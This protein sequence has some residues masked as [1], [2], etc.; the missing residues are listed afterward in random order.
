MDFVRR[1]L[2]GLRPTS[3]PP[4]T[5]DAGHA[6][7]QLLVEA[8]VALAEDRLE[9]DVERVMHVVVRAAHALT[10]GAAV[11][12][13][14]GR[15]GALHRFASE[16]ADGCVRE[17][18]ARSDL[19]A[20]LVLQLGRLGRPLGPRDLDAEVGRTLGGLAPHGFCAV[21][22]GTEPAGV[23]LLVDASPESEL[24]EDAVASVAML[25]VLAGGALRQARRVGRLRQ[26]R[27]ELR[28]LTAHML[29]ERDRE[30]RH[31]AHL[32]HEGTCQRLAAANAHL[33]ALDP[34]LAG[35]TE[36]ARLRDART[37]VKQ[38]LGELR[39]LAHELRPP[40]LEDF[41]YVHALRWYL[42]RLQTRDGVAPSLEVEGREARFPIEIE[43]AL[44]RATEDAL[45]AVASS[46]GLRSLRV[47]FRRDEAAVRVEIAGGPLPTL[48][49][50]AM[51]ERLRPFGGAVKVMP[52]PNAATVIEVNVPTP[53]N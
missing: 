19:L 24:T 33:Q 39:D 2:T 17:T 41:G 50:T 51:R 38:T 42:A 34:L 25:G 16:G 28:S 53:L 12:A 44:Y 26:S 46:D 4:S 36:R 40:V 5:P 48:N 37:L 21:P 45:L 30:L 18:L 31:T 7:C 32:L 47:R 3:A 35:T 8:A 22:L 9:P 52:A 13:L 1:F 23:L 27:E 15:D 20:A 29:T 11:L 43:G 49:L 10:G 14:V 6:R